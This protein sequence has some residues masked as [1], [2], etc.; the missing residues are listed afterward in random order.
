MNKIPPLLLLVVFFAVTIGLPFGL[1]V[2]LTR[3]RRRSMR[4]IREG[5]AGQGWRYRLRRWQG[6]PTAFRIDGTTRSGLSWIMTS[7]NTRG[8]DKGWSVVAELRVPILGGEV[9][10][11]VLPREAGHG[12]AVL[13]GAIPAG[14][15]AR[16]AAFSGAIGSAVELFQN[17]QE[18][19]SGLAVFD[20]R[21]V[22]LVLPKQI[23]KQPVDAALAQ[24]VLSWPDR[25]DRAAFLAGLARPVRLA[26]TGPIAGPAELEHG[27]LFRVP[28]RRLLRARSRAAEFA[29]AADVVRPRGCPDSET[30]RKSCRYVGTWSLWQQLQE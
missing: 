11:A 28:G 2:L 1:Y 4:E 9:D 19:A 5:A 25:R 7:G 29:C 3:A 22:V 10:L 15:K 30:I 23:Q 17:A 20:T 6:N 21:Y 24:R 27:F 14:A 13:R 18:L 26:P 12:D 8:Y 16:V